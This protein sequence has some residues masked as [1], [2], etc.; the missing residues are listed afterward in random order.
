MALSVLHVKAF[1][2]QDNLTVSL[3]EQ[4]QLVF[5][6]QKALFLSCVLKRRLS[7]STDAAANQA[8]NEVSQHLPAESVGARKMF[9]L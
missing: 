1:F 4:T 5:S 8:C 7:F 6:V 3:T 9:V 2:F